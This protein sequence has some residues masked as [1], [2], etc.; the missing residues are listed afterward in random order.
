M[1][2]TTA[3]IDT[4]SP[5]ET[6]TIGSTSPHMS[7]SYS[8]HVNVIDTRLGQHTQEVAWT[9][10]VT[11]RNDATSTEMGEFGDAVDA[12]IRE[13]NREATRLNAAHRASRA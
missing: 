2:T 1:N 6:R 5:Y 9:R 7:G 12:A 4:T 13:A 8:T 11:R 3:S 10:R